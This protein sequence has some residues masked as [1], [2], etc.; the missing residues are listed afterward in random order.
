MLTAASLGLLH[1]GKAV[2]QTRWSHLQ[3]Q[4]FEFLVCDKSHPR[5]IPPKTKGCSESLSGLLLCEQGQAL[6]QRA[7]AGVEETPIGELWSETGFALTSARLNCKC[8]DVISIGEWVR[9]VVGV[10]SVAMRNWTFDMLGHVANHRRSIG[11]K[12]WFDFC[13]LLPG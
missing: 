8:R 5:H 2:L 12:C 9:G 10:T 13:A 7:E 11:V 3:E 6:Q 1:V 4:T